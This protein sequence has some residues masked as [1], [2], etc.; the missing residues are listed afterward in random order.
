[1][2]NQ[3]SQTCSSPFSAKP[4]ESFFLDL[5]GAFQYP[6]KERVEIPLAEIQKYFMIVSARLRGW[7]AGRK[8]DS[9]ES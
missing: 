6:Q 2:K 8:D 1:V 3:E 9:W 4:N 7:T 5:G